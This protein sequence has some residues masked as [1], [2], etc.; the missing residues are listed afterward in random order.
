MKTLRYDS[1]NPFTGQP[2][3]YDDPNLRWGDPGY[4]LEP[5]DIGFVPYPGQIIPRP[6]KPKKK[7]FRRIP[8]Q[9]TEPP[10]LVPTAMN[11]FRYNIA[12][13]ASGGFTTRAVRGSQAD[14][15]AITTAIATAVGVT[16]AQVEAVVAQLFSKILDCS[17]TCGWSPELYGC[18]SFRPTSGGNEALPTDFQNAD[19]INADVALTLSVEKIRQWR[20][21]LS[22]E[23][24]G[25]VG[26]LTPVIDSI[27]DMT[28]SQPDKYTA[29]NVV[30]LRGE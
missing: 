19:D 14:Q 18:I 23:S 1:I 30:Q 24:M 3:T 5:G 16:N 4:Y 11:T 29:A 2:F 15:T 25:E 8:R 10:P 27:I 28:T 6:P 12:P 17:T 22:L 26:L 7:P 9:K 21:T 13:L 20:S